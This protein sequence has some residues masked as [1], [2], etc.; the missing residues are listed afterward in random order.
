MLPLTY[1][2]F[3]ALAALWSAQ[4]HGVDV[5]IL[6]IGLG[7]RLDAFNVIDADVAVITSIGLDHQ[8][9]LG[10]TREAIG[11]ERSWNFTRWTARGIGCRICPAPSFSAVSICS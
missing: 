6:E 5:A 4:H 1:F 8:S 10:D 7:G 3:S 9:F 11:A 2:E